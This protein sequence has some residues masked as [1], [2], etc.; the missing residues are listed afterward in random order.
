MSRKGVSRP[1]ILKFQSKKKIFDAAQR[2]QSTIALA[3]V[4]KQRAFFA[5]ATIFQKL[6]SWLNH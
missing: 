6:R 2:S 1:N 3:N 5:R 4:S